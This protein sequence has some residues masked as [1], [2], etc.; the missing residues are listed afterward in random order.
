MSTIYAQYAWVVPLLP[1]VAFIFVMTLGRAA[2]GLAVWT[3][4]VASVGSLMLSLCIMQEQLMGANNEFSGK[5]TWF[6]VG[7]VQVSLGIE[8]TQ[9]TTLLLCVI[10]LLHVCGLI[11]SASYMSRDGRAGLFCGYMSLLGCAMMGLVLAADMLTLFACWQLLGLASVLLAGFWHERNGAKETVM[12]LYIFAAVGDLALLLA[13][14]LL[15]W[16]MPE[17]ALD[18]A[19]IQNVFEGQATNMAKWITALISALLLIAAAAKSGLFPFHLWL[20]HLGPVPLP[21]KAAMFCMALAPAGIVLLLRAMAALQASPLIM[22]TAAWLGAASALI[23]AAAAAMQ[24]K[25]ARMAGYVAV[26]QVGLMLLGVG[27]YAT[28]GTVYLLIGYS[29]AGFLMV[30]GYGALH[31]AAG[32]ARRRSPRSLARWVTAIGALSLAGVPPLPGFWAYQQ[33]LQAALSTHVLLFAAALAA[34]AGTAFYAGRAIMLLSDELRHAEAPGRA[35]GIVPA[36]LALLLVLLA[37]IELIWGKQGGL[38]QWLQVDVTSYDWS[39]WLPLLL[40]SGCGLYLAVHHRHS[41]SR[42]THTNSSIFSW[43]DAVLDGAFR[44]FGAKLMA[45]LDKVGH[46]LQRLDERMMEALPSLMAD[47]WERRGRRRK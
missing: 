35:Q 23:G 8:V 29:L 18:F 26:S 36:A 31:P 47:V 16:Y 5:F 38:F 39:V 40:S 1:L 7:S 37:A 20:Q 22:E 44:R 19:S 42:E 43:A 34:L 46:W 41:I 12:R 28:S 15:F 4:I 6:K 9:L 30:L 3:A 21:A 45:G 24:H 2:E 32:E 33:L 10:S 17:H 13:I 27:T 11:Y 14:L 25:L